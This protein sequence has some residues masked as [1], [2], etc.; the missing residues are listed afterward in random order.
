MVVTTLKKFISTGLEAFLSLWRYRSGNVV[1]IQIILPQQIC[2]VILPTRILAHDNCNSTDILYTY[3][4]CSV[5]FCV[6]PPGGAGRDGGCPGRPV[7]GRARHSDDSQHIP[8]RR[9]VRQERHTRRAATQGDHQ[10]LQEAQ[11][12]LAHGLPAGPGRQGRRESQGRRSLS[13]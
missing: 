10:H 9:R 3:D 2:H 7:A 12:T 1:K 11:D 5:W 13:P 4:D 8:L 6:C